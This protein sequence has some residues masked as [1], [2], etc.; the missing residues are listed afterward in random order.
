MNVI[1]KQIFLRDRRETLDRLDVWQRVVDQIA[2]IYGG[3]A[4]LICQLTDTGIRPVVSSVQDSNPFAV[5]TTFPLEAHTFCDEVITTND[6]LYVSN[7]EEDPNWSSSSAWREFGFC[8]YYGLPIKW[9]D[10]NMFGT[11]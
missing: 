6:S 1:N 7:V 5:G 2:E 11:I 10:G 8:S 9:P 3:A 4:S